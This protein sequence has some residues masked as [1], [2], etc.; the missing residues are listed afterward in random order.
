MHP[1]YLSGHASYGGGAGGI[2]KKYFGSDK[3]DPPLALSSNASVAGP[4]TRT[5]NSIDQAIKENGDSRVFVGVH[6]QFSSDEGS[7]QG[8]NA[9]NEV[10]Q[11]FKAGNKFL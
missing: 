4:I 5:F 3:I 1:D 9:A 8:L 2:L 11:S 7:K 10:W 6:F